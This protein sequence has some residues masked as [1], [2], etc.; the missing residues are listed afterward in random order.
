MSQR[1]FIAACAA[2]AAA[3][4]AVPAL[5]DQAIEIRFVAE[6]AGQP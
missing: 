2:A 4:A 1:P 3:F 5:A 6:M